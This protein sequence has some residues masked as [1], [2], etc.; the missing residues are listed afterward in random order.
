MRV[1]SETSCSKVFSSPYDFGS[2]SL[3]TSRRSSPRARATSSAARSPS[4]ADGEN[5]QTLERSSEHR[6]D[7][8]DAP[9]RK[10]V[11]KPTHQLMRDVEQSIGLAEGACDLGDQLA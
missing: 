10:R 8:P 5:A 6:T 9:Y 11:E 1:R 2:R 3:S 7:A 4:T